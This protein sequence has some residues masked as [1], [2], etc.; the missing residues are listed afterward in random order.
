M[1]GGSLGCSDHSLVEFTILRDMGQVKSRA[2]TLDFRRANFQLFKELVDEPPW[3]TVLRDKGAEQ[4]WQLFKDIFLRAHEL[5]LPICKKSDKEG[6]R[7]AWLSKDLLVKIKCKRE[8]HRQWKHIL[9]RIQG[10]HLGV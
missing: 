7:L 3:E 6:K 2:R 8:M 10:Y 9:G 5:F 1:I 4:T